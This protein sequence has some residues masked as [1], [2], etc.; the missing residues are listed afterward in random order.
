MPSIVNFQ[1]LCEDFE[2]DDWN[3]D[4]FIENDTDD[5]DLDQ[6]PTNLVGMLY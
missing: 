3:D 1:N 6:F 4:S 5:I 2:L